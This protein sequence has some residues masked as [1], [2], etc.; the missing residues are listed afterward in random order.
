VVD[1]A[2]RA[3]DR[4]RA[5][6]AEGVVD[7]DLGAAEIDPLANAVRRAAERHDQLIELARPRGV[8]DVAEERLPAVREQLLRTSQPPRSSCSEYE[9]GDEAV[10]GRR[11]RKSTRLNSSHSQISYAVFCLKKKKEVPF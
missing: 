11:D 1:G 5:A 8:E 7:D 2:E 4:G 10:T 6:A 9:A 3:S